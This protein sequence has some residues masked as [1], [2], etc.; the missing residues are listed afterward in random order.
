M[1]FVR[2]NFHG[3][4]TEHDSFGL[5]RT[6]YIYTTHLRKKTVLLG[7]RIQIK[8]GFIEQGI[9]YNG[10]NFQAKSNGESCENTMKAV[11]L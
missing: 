3:P 8:D 2:L 10:L 7:V 4:D 9:V 1:N 6:L 5:K 11:Q